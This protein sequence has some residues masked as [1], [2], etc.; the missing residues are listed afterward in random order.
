[1]DYLDLYP[2]PIWDTTSPLSVVGL[3]RPVQTLEDCWCM[4]FHYPCALGLDF[5]KDSSKPILQASCSTIFEDSHGGLM[6]LFLLWKG[7]VKRSTQAYVQYLSP[8]AG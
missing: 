8:R 2:R 1:M 5:P 6:P 7:L 3:N 4:V